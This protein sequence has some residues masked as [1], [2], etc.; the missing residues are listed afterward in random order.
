MPRYTT[1]PAY[2]HALRDIR[3]GTAAAAMIGLFVNLLHLAMPLFT[4]QI[5]DRVIASGSY[6]TLVALAG[7][8]VVVLGF[9]AVLD[10]LRHRIF[11]ILG[12]QVAGR[13]GRDVFEASVETTLRDGAAAAAGSIRDLGDLRSFIA[14]GAIALP[15]DLAMAPLFLFVLWLLH[16]VY[17]LVGLTAAL[18]LSSIAI[19]T[20]VLA[21]RP[22]ARATLAAGNVHIETAAAIRNA[23]VIT[24]MGMLPAVARRWRRSQAEALDSVERRRAVAKA[25]ASAAKALRVGLQVAVLS[26][27]A[28]LVIQR[29]VSGGTII[30]ASV[31]MARLL[32]PF[33]QMIEG[34][35]QWVDAMGAGERLRE[36]L[37]RGATRRSRSPIRVARGRLTA[38]RVGYVPP[39]QDTPLIRNVSFQIEAGELLGIVG[40]SGAGKSTLARLVVGLW[41]PTAGGIYLDGQSTYT[42]ERGSFGEAVGYLPQDPLLLDGTVRDNIS[43][44]RDGDMTEVVAAARLAGVHELIGTLPQGYETRLA[45]AGSRLSGGQRQRIALARAVFGEPKLLVLDEPN[46]NLDAEG[47]AALVEAIEIARRRGTTVLVIAQRMSI[48]KRADKLMVMKDGTVAQFGDRVEVLAALGPRRA[49]QGITPIPSREG[50]K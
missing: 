24:A 32:L 4:I 33:E 18:I 23:E 48:L 39:G 50:V 41:A 22:T 10:Y 19:A 16:P 30:A 8:V 45:D 36:V 46:S 31:L 26:T 34:W 43:R 7:L 37:N 3:R 47:E 44:F 25:L 17:G 38:D 21:R 12:A 5:Y 13:L 9:Q 11:A 49:G 14:S 27:G 2:R 20:E 6:E 40:P 15:M 42:H 1:T 29:E 28:A 35:R